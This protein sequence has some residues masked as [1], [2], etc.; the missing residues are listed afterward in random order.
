MFY[1]RLDYRIYDICLMIYLF[2]TEEL[3]LKQYKNER[4]RFRMNFKTVS[5]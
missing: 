5:L 3:Q 1:E 2:C 4:Q